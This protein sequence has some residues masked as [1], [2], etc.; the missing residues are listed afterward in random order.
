MSPLVNEF[1]T[2]NLVVIG[3]IV[4]V[5]IVFLRLSEEAWTIEDRASREQ[6]TRDR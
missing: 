3:L 5:G 4:M 2:M 1:A 6:I